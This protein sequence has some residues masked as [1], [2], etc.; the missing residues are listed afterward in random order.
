MQIFE[1]GPE[2][3]SKIAGGQPRQTGGIYKWQKRTASRLR[4]M[5]R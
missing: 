2:I 1:T 5:S 3:I 4:K